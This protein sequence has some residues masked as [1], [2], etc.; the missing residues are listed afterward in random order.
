MDFPQ[1]HL[2]NEAN[3]VD[4]IYVLRDI[5]KLFDKPNIL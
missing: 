1:N 5:F 3:D 4:W 2:C